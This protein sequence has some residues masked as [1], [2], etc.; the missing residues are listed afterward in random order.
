MTTKE[1]MYQLAPICYQSLDEQGMFV[2]V[3]PT[4]LK[5]LGY[6]KEEVIGRSFSEFIADIPELFQKRF[7]HF[8][9]KGRVCGIV[10][11]MKKKDGTTRWVEYD[12]VIERNEQGD[13]VRTHCV[14]RDVSKR[15][16]TEDELKDR[17]EALKTIE[18]IVVDREMKMIELKEEINAL[19]EQLHAN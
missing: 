4:W 7:S 14:F 18:K 19:K 6:T 17:V 16:K 15:K 12:G 1:L 13:F 8:K 2:D 5:T 9:E 3:N 10:F 11:Q